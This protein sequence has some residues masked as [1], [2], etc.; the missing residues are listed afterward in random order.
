MRPATFYAYG[1]CIFAGSRATF[2]RCGQRVKAKVRTKRATRQAIEET[3]S[4]SIFTPEAVQAWR[5]AF[6]SR[7][8][9]EGPEGKGCA[10]LLQLDHSTGA[11]PICPQGGEVS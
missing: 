7:S 11:K 8:Q 9:G 1:V 10:D 2:S 5:L 3:Q 6:V 4:L